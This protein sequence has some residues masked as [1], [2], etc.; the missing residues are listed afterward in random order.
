MSMDE[1]EQEEEEQTE[2][3]H[4][5]TRSIRASNEEDHEVSS[6]S[7]KS[8]RSGITSKLDMYLSKKRKGG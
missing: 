4:V 2:R 3:G 1:D 7:K 6:T 8:K 5:K